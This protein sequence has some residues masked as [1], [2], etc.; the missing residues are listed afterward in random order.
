[1][2]EM[3]RERR[4]RSDFIIIIKNPILLHYTAT[5]YSTPIRAVLD[6]CKVVLKLQLCIVCFWE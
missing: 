2:Q 6:R 4:K 3:K 5:R 1:M